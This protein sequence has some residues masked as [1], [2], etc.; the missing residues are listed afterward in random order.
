M[1]LL[2][3]TLAAVIVIA[4]LPVK[5]AANFVGAERTG[6]GAVL[7]AVVLQFVLVTI[8]RVLMPDGLAEI[9]AALLVGS[10]VY[11]YAL[12]TSV[13]KGFIISIIATVIAVIAVIML[14]TSFA[15]LASAT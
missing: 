3:L 7:L 6:F 14:G 13:M 9:L 12:G 4:V 10:I 8:A 2:L 11:A 1:S 15:L 5:F